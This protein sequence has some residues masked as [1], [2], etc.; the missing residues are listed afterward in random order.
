M[1]GEKSNHQNAILQFIAKNGNQAEKRRA[2]LLL[3][4]GQE[5]TTREIAE[6]IDLSPSRVRYWLREYRS[7]GLSV[8][9]TEL[10]EIGLKSIKIDSIEVPR[11]E[12]T[13][14]EV[15]ETQSTAIEGEEPSQ[16][17]MLV[18]DLREMYQVDLAHAHFVA[19]LTLALFDIT[20]ELHQLPKDRRSLAEVA[21]TL[22]N[23]GLSAHPEKHDSAGRD[24]L[25]KRNL[26]GFD[27]TDQRILAFSTAMHRKKINPKR[28]KREMVNTNLPLEAMDEAMLIAALVR[29]ADGLDYSGDQSTNLK[30]YQIEPEEIILAIVGPS[31]TENASRAM[32]K[33][34]LWEYIF[35]IPISFL[36]NGERVKPAEKSSGLESALPRIKK[37]KSPGVLSD[38]PMSEAGRKI[39]RFHFYRMLQNEPDTRLGEDIEA[40]H[41]MRVATRRMRS[42]TPIFAPYFDKRIV[43]RF[44]KDLRRTGSALGRVRDLDVFMDKAQNYVSSDEGLDPGALDP[45][46]SDWKVAREEARKVMLEYLESKRYKEFL[47]DFSTFLVTDGAG[48]RKQ[49]VDRPSSFTVFQAVPL[50]IYQRESVVRGYSHVIQDAPLGTLHALRIDIKRFRYALEFF[51]EVLGEDAKP[52]IEVSVRLQDHLGDL[53]DADVACQILID[54][55]DQWREKDRREQINISGVTHYL[56]AKQKELRHLIETFPSAW[57]EFNHPRVRHQLAQ[58]VSN[59]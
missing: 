50:L 40:L 9:P 27:D 29:I 26:I 45:L 59:L 4:Y 56:V 15:G 5:H 22:H 44:N 58:A 31:A 24:I 42:A 49:R 28:V 34:D 23:I 20:V 51:R 2:E 11:P 35:S 36:I 16:P 7:K 32:T 33:S 18:S 3:L 57:E 30:T 37:L 41:D 25:L 53:N 1:P 21:G 55:L 38:D 54:F 10:I 8:F 19:D 52:L 46:I 17:E 14:S 12:Q 39:L 6:G 13:S 43:R 48:V 47:Q